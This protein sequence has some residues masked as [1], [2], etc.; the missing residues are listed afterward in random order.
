LSRIIF[1]TRSSE[2]ICHKRANQQSKSHQEIVLTWIFRQ[3]NVCLPAVW[4]IQSCSLRTCQEYS[5]VSSVLFLSERRETRIKLNISYIQAHFSFLDCGHGS[6]SADDAACPSPFVVPKAVSLQ[7]VPAPTL[8]FYFLI[9]TIG[10]LC[11][12]FDQQ[13]ICTIINSSLSVPA[14]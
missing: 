10:F 4:I 13:H 1:L 7:I 3:R 9:S 2:H 11:F 6:A 8:H 14:K 5:D 12:I